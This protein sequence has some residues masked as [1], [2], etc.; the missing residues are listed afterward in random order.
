MKSTPVGRFATITTAILIG[1]VAGNGPAAAAPPEKLFDAHA[2]GAKGTI[3]LVAPSTLAPSDVT[4]SASP[5]SDD[6]SL[7][8][9]G[10]L[11]LGTIGVTET[12]AEATED[13]S[14]LD[15]ATAS[16]TVA[17]V[18]L[19][20]GLVRADSLTA[21]ATATDDANADVTATGDSTFTNLRVS[22]VLIANP[23]ANT[24]ITLPLGTVVIN[25]QLSTADGIV[26][27][28]LRATLTGGIQVV[29]GHAAAS[30]TEPGNPCPAPQPDQ[31]T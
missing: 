13:A 30:L 19:L 27:K 7:T 29:V 12:S 17:S 31:S 14:G 15:T 9:A 11:G 1:L 21:T 18:Q 22:G 10:L 8:T 2:Y 16:A 28:A 25:E 3:P 6:N 26:V 20:S 24:A 5:A 4:C 23:A